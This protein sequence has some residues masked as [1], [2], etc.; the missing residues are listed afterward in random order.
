MGK[1]WVARP[2]LGQARW[3]GQLRS[4][5]EVSRNGQTTKG[6]VTLRVGRA[7]LISKDFTRRSHAPW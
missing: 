2:G 5:A 1:W 3:M 6:V 4:M 7:L